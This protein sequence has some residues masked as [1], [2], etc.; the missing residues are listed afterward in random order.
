MPLVT[1][2]YLG[3]DKT[4]SSWLFRAM[5]KHPS[6]YVPDAKDIYFFDRF[7]HRGHSWYDS[8][9]QAGSNAVVRM[10]ISHD[11]LMSVDAPARIR[12][13]SSDVKLFVI[14]RHPLARSIS[15][16]Q[17]LRRS[18]MTTLR[19]EDEIH[20]TPEIITNSLYT[21]HLARYED[22]FGRNAVQLFSFDDLAS[23]PVRFSRSLYD[24]LGLA[25]DQSLIPPPERGA[26]EARAP[27][28]AKVAKSG[29]ILAREMGFE[30]L[31]GRIKGNPV[32]NMALYR[33]LGHNY[34][35]DIVERSGRHLMERYF[36]EE[37]HALRDLYNIHLHAIH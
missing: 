32:V 12:H 18:G 3:P 23:D 10:D 33:P 4:G 26:T 20:R 29:A 2:I 30:D 37:V 14:V 19:F 22:V 5:Q 31:L 7:Y 25:F 35:D 21:R 8:K 13:Y 36:D 1:H 28:I 16:Y 34:A 24:Y 9:F 15:H 17:Y 6:A 27:L 11:Y